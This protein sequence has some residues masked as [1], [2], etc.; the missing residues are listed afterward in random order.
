MT[1]S[2]LQ[3]ID[4]NKPRWCKPKTPEEPTFPVDRRRRRQ[5]TT[6][7]ACRSSTE[8]M[9]DT[10]DQNKDLDLKTGLMDRLICMRVQSGVGWDLRLLEHSV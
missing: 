1:P 4:L 3:S 7:H 2:I 10:T 9:E 5:A 8:A 6:F